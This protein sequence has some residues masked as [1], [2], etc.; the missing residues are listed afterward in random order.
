MGAQPRLEIGEVSRSGE[1]AGDPG[2]GADAGRDPARL[3]LRAALHPRRCGLHARGFPNC[4]ALRQHRWPAARRSLRPSGEPVP[5]S[6][7]APGVRRRGLLRDAEGPGFEPASFRSTPSTCATGPG[8]ACCMPSIMWASPYRPARRWGWSTDPAAENPRS[9]RRSCGSSIRIRDPSSSTAS[10]S[11]ACRTAPAPLPAALPDGVPGSVGLAQSAP[12][13]PPPDRG[14]ARA[15]RPRQAGRAARRV[16]E[17]MHQVGLPRPRR[18]PAARVLRRPAPAHRHRPRP[19]A[20]A[21]PHRLRRTG[22]GPRRV[23]AGADPQ[24]LAV[25]PAAGARRRPFSS[26][27]TICRWSSISRTIS[28]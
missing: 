8:A 14:A 12:A 18:P 15:A 5:K 21:E 2:A 22:L 23:A 17:L 26:S 9:A 10:T 25:R 4:G 28:P 3:R 24:L 1:A 16:R 6:G 20:G 11:R 27:A 13:R 19:C 7:S